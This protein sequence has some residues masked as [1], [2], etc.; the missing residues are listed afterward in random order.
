MEYKF[1]GKTIEGE[2]V[3][4]LLPC[5]DVIRVFTDHKYE[6]DGL[7]HEYQTSED[8]IVIPETVGLF[9]GLKDR[10]A[11][12]IYQGDKCL[13]FNIPHEVEFN[14][15]A[16]GYWVYKNESYKDFVS[17]EANSNFKWENGQSDLIEITGTIHDN[18]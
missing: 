14:E 5:K 6:Q 15:G 1:R 10:N 12:E 9:T 17:F 8:F 13:C 18:Q 4:G 2:W 16:F 11:K 7:I 3:Y